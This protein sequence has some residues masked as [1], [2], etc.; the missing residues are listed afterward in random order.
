MQ[1]GEGIYYPSLISTLAIFPSGHS[2]AGRRRGLVDPVSPRPAAARRCFNVPKVEVDPREDRSHNDVE[3][4][5]TV[6]VGPFKNEAVLF[7]C[8]AEIVLPPR[9]SDRSVKLGLSSVQ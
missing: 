2:R 9:G 1:L 7:G 3:T 6:E 4:N 8:L 5:C